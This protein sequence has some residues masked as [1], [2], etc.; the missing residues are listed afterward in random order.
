MS[1]PIRH[2]AG[3]R[4]PLKG[5]GHLP[6]GR[7]ALVATLSAAVL[8][9]C[10]RS[11]VQVGA[12]DATVQYRQCLK[13]SPEVYRSSG[14]FDD[15][16]R[17]VKEVARDC[18]ISWSTVDSALGGL[19]AD[20][21]KD[22]V[23]SAKITIKQQ[24][25]DASGAVG[26]M[27]ARRRGGNAV[28]D[29]LNLRI[30][31]EFVKKGRELMARHQEI[32]EEIE[33]KYGVPAHYLVGYWGIETNYGAV[34]GSH[35][36]IPTLAKLGYNSS[37]RRFFSSELLGALL[38]IDRGYARRSQ[39]FGSFAGAMGQPQFMPSSYI[40]FAVDHNGDG[41]RDIWRTPADI[42]AS[43]ANYN[44][45]RGQWD[46]KI[47][48]AIFEVR[49]PRSLRLTK[50]GFYNLRALNDWRRDG[51]RGVGGRPLPDSDE[52]A[53]IYM[54]AGC[55]GPVF[56]IPG[57]FRA[58]MRYNNLIEYAFAVSVLAEKIKG[59]FEIRKSWPS[60]DYALTRWE[61]S[62]LQRRLRR[63]GYGRL[64]ADGILGKESRIAIQKYQK[65]KGL[66]PSGHANTRLYRHVRGKRGRGYADDIQRAGD[67]RAEATAR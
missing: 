49:L 28:R 65:R 11:A 7:V 15:Y 24:V 27:I 12:D 35:A 54:P 61:R 67:Q 22:K 45:E 55:G 18:G 20:S 10:S 1:L 6:L 34:T 9:G 16:I 17:K 37:R 48:S 32:L 25:A 13:R 8:A 59:D 66:C 52:E 58:I 4:R 57:N 40:Y 38:I 64:K 31:P 62:D 47:K 26:V 56:L 60:G 5:A 46:T 23:A 3:N 29:Y 42:F 36:V 50:T 63:M 2:Y 14:D 41:R 30:T 39:M 53:S 51:V 33:S 44:I 19:R 21:A 43:V